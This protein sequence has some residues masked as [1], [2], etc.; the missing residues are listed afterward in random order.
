NIQ[1]LQES[2][3]KLEEEKY[4]I[5]SKIEAKDSLVEKYLKQ[6]NDLETG[7]YVLN[8]RLSERVGEIEH[9]NVT[10][11]ENKLELANQRIEELNQKVALLEK[12]VKEYHET[13]T[14]LEE[15]LEEED[16]LSH[17]EASVTSE[18]LDSDDFE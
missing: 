5:Q 12:Q 14:S 15:E 7:N 13:M 18:L 4:D 1:K 16:I 8:K 10:E 2:L 6:I 17:R 9:R 11:Y 3:K